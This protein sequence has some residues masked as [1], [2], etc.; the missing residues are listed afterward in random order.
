M[1][2]S[3]MEPPHGIIKE[4]LADLFKQKVLSLVPK[5]LHIRRSGVTISKGPVFVHLE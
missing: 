5:K 1:T 4:T 2:R 3:R